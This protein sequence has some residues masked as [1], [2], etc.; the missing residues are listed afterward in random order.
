TG[1]TLNPEDAIEELNERFRENRVGYQFEG[2][3]IIKLDSSYIHSEI[4]KPVV[5]LLWNKKFLGANEEYLKAH[6]HYRKGRNKECL[7]E[8]LKAFESTLKVIC[9][10]KKWFYNQNDTSKKLIQVCFQNNLIPSYLQNQ[11][12]SLQNVIESGIPTIRN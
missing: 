1:S 11:F 2:N 7:A 6:E 4:T 8:C 10:E 3:E 9:K 12:S 5:S